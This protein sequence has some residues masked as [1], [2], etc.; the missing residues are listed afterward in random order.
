MKIKLKDLKSNPYRDLKKY[1]IQQDR[2]ENL[3]ASIE[4]T[5]FW[6][7]ILA[8]PSGKQYELAYGHN[9]LIALQQLGIEEIDIPIKTIPDADMVRIMATEN[10]EQYDENQAILIETVQAVKNYLDNELTK[11]ENIKEMPSHIM[12][13]LDGTRQE[14]LSRLKSKGVGQTTILKFLGKG[15]K[16][17]KI[18][19]ALEVLNS[20]EINP[21]AI[22]QFE[23]TGMGSAFTKAIK[24]INKDSSKSVDFKEQMRLAKKLNDSDRKIEGKSGGG[25]Y[26]STIKD[27]VKDE[28]TINKYTPIKKQSQ[29]SE[30]IIK[31]ENYIDELSTKTDN[32]RED[33]H[34]LILTEKEIGE[35]EENVRRKLLI[36][37]L[38]SLKKQIELV[39]TKNYKNEK[40][41]QNNDGIKCLTE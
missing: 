14:D 40:I 9:R 23:S 6:D 22:K 5:G 2:V 7:N 30:N 21:E 29:K 17:W 11:Y 32:L 31:Y 15:W 20:S 38:D 36:M 12:N 13:L 41:K 28:F 3:K 37:R 27:M 39:I 8:R 33:L 24:E 35:V 10:R 18:Q 4:Q 26:Y 34:N 16:Q 1:P 25:N 19:H